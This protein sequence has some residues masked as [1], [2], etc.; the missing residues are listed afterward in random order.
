MQSKLILDTGDIQLFQGDAANLDMLENDSVDL[1]CTSAPYNKGKMA[2]NNWQVKWYDGISDDM[3]QDEYEQQQVGVLNEL[4]R[5]AKDGASLAYVHKVQTKDWKMKHPILWLVKSKWNPIQEIIWN[6]QA[7]NQMDEARFWD[8]TERVYWLAKGKP[9]YFN[10][11][12]DSLRTIWDIQ[13]KPNEKVKHPAPFPLALP[14]RCIESFSRE[15]ELVLDCYVGS[16]TSAVAAK[17]LKRRFV[18]VD[19]STKYLEDAKLR[20]EQNTIW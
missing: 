5:V 4:Y 19:I 20:L 1:I 8:N 14:Y 10:P 12:C 18:G 17:M 2:M 6:R 13:F 16:G 15:G 3:P 7:T 9:K 11:K